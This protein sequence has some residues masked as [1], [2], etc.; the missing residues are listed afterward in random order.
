MY[1][2]VSPCQENTEQLWFKF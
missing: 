1:V 2:I